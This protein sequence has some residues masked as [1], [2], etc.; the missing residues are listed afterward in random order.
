M[1]PGTVSGVMTV[2]VLGPASETSAVEISV[3]APN[4]AHC[5]V[6]TLMRHGFKINIVSAALISTGEPVDRHYIAVA[7]PD[8]DA[9]GKLLGALAELDAHS[10]RICSSILMV[11]DGKRSNTRLAVLVGVLPIKALPLQ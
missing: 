11:E 8:T 3:E 10:I 1:G 2:A 5:F 6:G 4:E 7:V 9:I